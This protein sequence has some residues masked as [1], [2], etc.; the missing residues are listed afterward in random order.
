[1]IS[2]ISSPIFY[3]I[4]NIKRLFYHFVYLSFKELGAF[5][6]LTKIYDWNNIKIENILNINIP[7]KP[8]RIDKLLGKFFF[9]SENDV[10]IDLIKELIGEEGEEKILN[11]ADNIDKGIFIYFGKDLKNL[12]L[13]PK[14]NLNPYKNIYLNNNLHWS[15]YKLFDPEIG[16]IKFIWEPSRFSWVYWLCRA[17]IITKEKRYFKIFC[18]HFESWLSQN[19]PNEGPN[20]ISGQEIAF[21]IIAV[22]FAFFVFKDNFTEEELIKISKFI[23]VSAERIK[24]CLFISM[25][26]KNNHSLSEAC[27]LY[28][29]GVLFKYLRGSKNWQKV[30]KK[31]LQDEALCQIYSDGTYIQHS[32]N[33][34]RLMLHLIC[35][36][37]RLGRINNDNFNQEIICLLQKAGEFLTTFTDIQSGK[38]PNYGA[39]D[40]TLLIHIDNCDYLDYRPICQLVS[41]L[42]KKVKVFRKGPWDEGLIWLFGKECCNDFNNSLGHKK[43][44]YLDGGYFKLISKDSWCLIRCHSYIDR[45]SHCDPLHI[46]LW[47]YGLNI[48]R[49]SGSF[50]YFCPKDKKLENYFKSLEAHNTIKIDDSEPVFNLNRFFTFPLIQAKVIKIGDNYFSGEHYGFKRY[51][52]GVIHRR[53]VICDKN[54]KWQ[55]E[56][57]ILGKGRHHINLVWHLPL[58]YYDIKSSG[59]E[60]DFIYK[61]DINIKIKI[62]STSQIYFKILRGREDNMIGVESLYYGSI[63]DQ[64]LLVI[65]S[66]DEL[67]VHI[68]S[69]FILNNCRP[70]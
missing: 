20:W 19:R 23:F 40:S 47:F 14:W 43:N 50:M 4:R 10:P 25:R 5:K 37:V 57:F 11:I 16:D 53:E 21:R 62:E 60:I 28:T 41:F 49:D 63:N 65:K 48:L 26:L 44:N 24:K 12:G 17:Y 3:F 2:V 32:F 46:D 38:V 69:T 68:I 33:Y 52:W 13:P 59:K 54:D 39:N 1:M 31:I 30:G 70:L 36:A 18:K 7:L 27:G 9:N 55:V 8:E 42:T 51:P 29:A 15:E 6:Y 45:M 66:E 56:D 67:P 58:C 35:W 64:T 61:E 22:S 34:H